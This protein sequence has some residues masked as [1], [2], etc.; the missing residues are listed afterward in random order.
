M[1]QRIVNRKNI[2]TVPRP[3]YILKYRDG[4][5][6]NY[7]A[8]WSGCY[9]QMDASEVRYWRRKGVKVKDGE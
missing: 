7:L 9:D 6:F 2:I 3:K 4:R 1:K 8:F 5:A